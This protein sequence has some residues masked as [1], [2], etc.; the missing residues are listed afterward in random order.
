MPPSV[1]KI[2]D[3]IRH[4]LAK[5]QNISGLKAL[6][7]HAIPELIPLSEGLLRCV[8]N[9]KIIQHGGKGAQKRSG[10]KV[11]SGCRHLKWPLNR[12]LQPQNELGSNNHYYGNY[13]KQQ[14]FLGFAGGVILRRLLI[15]FVSF[16]LVIFHV[17]M[18]LMVW[19]Q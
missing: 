2:S 4:N 5:K 7:L 12:A 1:S 6:H 17:L 13:K 15:C 3:I 18:V 9:G 8:C 14:F 16:V 11:L 19:V 10:K